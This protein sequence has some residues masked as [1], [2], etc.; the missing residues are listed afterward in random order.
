[1]WTIK[2]AIGDARKASTESTQFYA[3]SLNDGFVNLCC[4]LSIASAVKRGRIG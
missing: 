4:R 1:M 2:D 3:L